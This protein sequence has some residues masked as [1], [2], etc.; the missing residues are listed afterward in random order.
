[1]KISKIPVI[2]ALSLT[3]V[4]SC[5]KDS[6]KIPVGSDFIPDTPGSNTPKAAKVEIVQTDGQWKMLVDG[7]PYYV[8]GAATNNFYGD[9]AGFGGNTIRTYSAKASDTKVMDILNEA[10]ENGL[11]VNLGIYIGRETDGFDYNDEAKVQAQ[12]LEAEASVKKYMNHPAVLFWS[13]GNE[14]EASYKNVRLWDAIN[15]I[16][17][18]I[19]ETDPNH[20]T[21]TT[22]ASAQKAHIDNILAK[23]P[24]IDFLCVNSY[25]PTVKNTVNTVR[26]AGWKKPVMI[27]EFGPRGTWSMNPEP[28]RQLP[29]DGVSAG[30]PALVEETSTE[31]EAKYLEIWQ[32]GVKPFE[33]QGCLGSFVFV[34]GYQT[35]GEVLNWYG[36][37][38][39]DGYS[40][41]AADAMQ[42][43]WTGKYPEKRAPV[44]ASRKTD[45]LLNGKAAEDA[46][47]VA[48]NS[49]NTAKVIATSPCGAK[50]RYNWIIFREGD[51]SSDGSIPDGIAGLITDPSKSEITF[52]AP[53]G[54]GAYRLYAFA[55]DD[56]NRKAASAC[57]PFKVE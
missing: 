48:P 6:Y 56:E 1:M 37:F 43:C 33:A 34:W 29:W 26:N 40:Y 55:L 2:I 49:S 38:N 8:N 20:P 23:C 46:V 14:A 28:E 18:M 16:A 53:A 11:M 45:M 24:E 13:I 15:D 17:K 27:T 9:V 3:A 39:K 19:H 21:T 41:G 51:K 31:K 50:L 47:K 57:I 52:K 22:L 32:E 42:Y 4:M 10:H 7:E 35:H 30:K 5:A 12:L 36:L 54:V 25:Y 44:I